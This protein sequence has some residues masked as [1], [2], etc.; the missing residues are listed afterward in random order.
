M[1]E[2]AEVIDAQTVRFRR[3]LPAPV[4]RVWAYLVESEKRRT[5]LAAGDMELRPGARFTL[6]FKHRELSAEP[7]EAG[8]SDY[9]G[10]HPAEIVEV[11]PPHRLVITWGEGMQ[12]M[13]A[14]SEVVFELESQDT[15]TRLTITHRKLDTPT[16]AKE[17]AMGWHTHVGLLEDAL[18]GREPRWF[19][20]SFRAIKPVYDSIFPGVPDFL[21]KTADRKDPS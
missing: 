10:A 11:D 14:I 1:N 19:W 13:A 3:L 2:A 7:V 16:T 12:D 6:Q 21:D 17:V 9:E 20:T 8:A 4:E 15:G 5:W 18:A